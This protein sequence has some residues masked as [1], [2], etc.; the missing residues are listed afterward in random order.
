[1]MRNG[2]SFVLRILSKNFQYTSDEGS[3]LEVMHIQDWETRIR[4][5]MFLGNLRLVLGHPT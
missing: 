4:Q 3:R 1:M 5:G 2:R